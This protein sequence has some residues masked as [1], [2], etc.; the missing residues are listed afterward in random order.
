MTTTVAEYVVQQIA[1]WGSQFVFGLA[2]DTVIPLLEALRRQDRVRYVGARHEEGA[3]FMASAYA[4][5][6]GRL[7][8]CMA[9]A[10]PATVHLLNGVYDAHMDRVPLLALTGQSETRL[11]GTRWPQTIN[12]DLLY[13]DAVCFNHTLASPEQLPE[14]LYAAMRRAV[15]VPGAA[16]L[17]LPVDLQMQL[18]PGPVRPRP[19]YLTERPEPGRQSLADAAS[20]LD[21]A[22][23]PLLFV[24]QGA[25]GQQALVLDLAEKLDAP[26][27]HTIPA[28]GIIPTAHPRNLGVIGEFGTP[29]AADAFSQADVVLVIGSTWWQPEYV[30]DARF[31]QIDHHRANLGLTFP[32]DVGLAGDAGRVL[33]SLLNMVQGGRRDP[34]RHTVERLRAALAESLGTDR[35]SAHGEVPLAAGNGRQDPRGGVSPRQV[36]AAL[37]EAMAPD[38]VLCLDVGENLF[39]VARLFQARHQQVLLSGNWRSMGFGL[40][41]AIAA[42]LAYP[43]RQVVA[44]VGDGGFAMTMAELATAAAYRLPITVIILNN[45][46]L[47]QEGHT[48]VRTGLEPFGVSLHN[49]D[50]AA[51][52]HSCGAQG[53]AVDKAQDLPLVLGRALGSGVPT[54]IDVDTQPLM[55]QVPRPRGTLK[56]QPPSKAE[57]AAWLRAP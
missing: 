39:W 27:I 40:P 36:M 54:V 51:F 56:P 11:L 16:R 24:G 5:L 33:S 13:Q 18:A 37:T 55:P 17:G 46:T 25:R 22:Q 29:M 20:L 48:Q 32:A 49:P 3:A 9:E 42:A 21:R 44:V 14:I 8:V 26:I 31:I 41:A 4:K 43:R 50:F 2:G 12:Q 19:A 45:R 15:S 1:A 47:A 10:G 23:R 30:P 7:G 35:G 34:W 6:T 57:Q 52:A 38:A 53:F 28:M